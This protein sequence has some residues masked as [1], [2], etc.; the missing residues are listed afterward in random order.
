M[1]VHGAKMES[2]VFLSAPP[3]YSVLDRRD[4]P[5][6]KNRL[7]NLAFEDGNLSYEGKDDPEEPKSVPA[8]VFK[9]GYVGATACFHCLPY[10]DRN[11]YSVYALDAL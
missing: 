8:N 3:A 11:I 1:Y 5:V 4:G 7:L 6:A 2:S 10:F 9:Q